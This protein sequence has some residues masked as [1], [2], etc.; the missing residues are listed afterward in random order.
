MLGS[1]GCARPPPFP[2]GVS[3]PGDVSPELELQLELQLELEEDPPGPP[4]GASPPPRPGEVS[5]ELSARSWS[6]SWKG[7]KTPPDP[8]P[9]RGASPAPPQRGQ[10]R[11]GAGAGAGAGARPPGPLRGASPR[12]R[13]GEVSL[14]RP[15][16]PAG[17]EPEPEPDPRED[18]QDLPV[19]VRWGGEGRPECA[20]LANGGR[21]VRRAALRR[22][23]E[24]R[25]PHPSAS[26]PQTRR[27]VAAAARQELCD[28]LQSLC[29]SVQTREPRSARAR[30]SNQNLFFA[31]FGSSILYH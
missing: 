7:R 22:A 31:F 1:E 29:V 26:S 25:Q 6:W 15:P 17:L 30:A 8:G 5:P 14:P 27:S 21:G 3:R 18:P 20:R 9:P 2:G 10:P 19:R 28:P 13:P 24:P 11:A 16:P 23:R 12:P 4:R